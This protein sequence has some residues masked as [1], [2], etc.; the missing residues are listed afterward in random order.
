MLFLFRIKSGFFSV[1]LT[2]EG[3]RPSKGVHVLKDGHQL[4]G[5]GGSAETQERQGVLLGFSLMEVFLWTWTPP[6][7]SG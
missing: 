3:R 6:E 1:L 7:A 2:L 4:E 5:P